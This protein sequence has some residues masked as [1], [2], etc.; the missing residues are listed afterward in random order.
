MLLG[1]DWEGT[2]MAG[3]ALFLQ[4]IMVRLWGFYTGVMQLWSN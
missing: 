3:L 1:S 2:E 4:S